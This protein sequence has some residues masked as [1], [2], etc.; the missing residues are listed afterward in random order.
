MRRLITAAILCST[1]LILPAAVGAQHIVKPGDSLW[2]IARNNHMFYSR[3]IELNPQIADPNKI[4]IGQKIYIADVN[5]ADQIIEYALA[6]QPGTHYFYGGNDLDAPIYTDC[7][8]WTKAIYEKFGVVLPRT[9]WEQSKTGQPLTFEQIEKGDLLFFGDNG[10]VSHVGIYM[11][12]YQG[13]K[14]WISN[15]NAKKNVVILGMT[16]SWTQSRFLWA[17]RVF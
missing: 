9:S 4:H 10:R 13:K 8:G 2:Q 16:D 5:K 14:R 6:L 11:G 7:S 12:E 1:L 15:L 17:T 3:L